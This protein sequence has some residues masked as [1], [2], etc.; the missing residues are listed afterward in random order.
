MLGILPS[1]KTMKP[2]T[3]NHEATANKYGL[4]IDKNKHWAY[5]RFADSNEPLFAIRTWELDAMP[6]DKLRE[7]LE[8]KL[9]H[10]TPVKITVPENT[11]PRKPSG[12]FAKSERK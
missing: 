4:T 11:R 2:T 6:S 5:I 10:Y 8:V 3:T 7:T 9:A 1:K 12:R